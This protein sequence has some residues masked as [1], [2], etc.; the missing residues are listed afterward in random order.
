[1]KFLRNLIL[2][3]VVAMSGSLTTAFQT[4]VAQGQGVVQTQQPGPPGTF[5]VHVRLIPVD[6]I[7]TDP[8][9]H[10]ITDL[11]REDFQ[12]LENGRPQEIRHFSVQTFTADAP[13]PGQRPLLRNVPTLELAPQLART[14]L[15]LMGRGRHQTPLKAVDAL[16]QFVR[17]DLLPQDRVAV[18]AYNSATDF[19]TDH[20]R[21][22]QVL[23]RYKKANDKI[24]SWLELHLRG[25]ATVYGIKDVPKSVQPEIDRIFA[26]TQTL[27]SRQVPPGRITEKGTIIRDWD[28]AADVF[29]RDTDRASETDARRAV[30]DQIAE[31][32]GPG[33]QI[34]QNMIRFDTIDAAF[35]TF[36]L[37]F[38]EFAP[39]AGGSFQDLQN[40]FT[41]IEYLRYMEGEKHLIFFSGDGLLFPNGN[42]EYDKGL[43]AMSNDARVAI[44]SFQTSGTFA[45]P[46]IVPTKG[47]VL[48]TQPRGSTSPVSPPPPVLSQ[49]NWSRS[50][51][52]ST[53]GSFSALTGGRA[54]IG[55]DIGKAL[56]RLDETTRVEYLLGYYPKDERWDGQYRQIQVKLNRPGTKVSFRHGYYARDTLRP[57]DREEFLAFS[58]I[59][60]AGAY[61]SEVGDIPLKITAAREAGSQPQIKVDLQIDPEKVGFKMV[62]LRHVGRLRI[63]IFYADA[64]G[65]SLGDDWKTVDMELQE[66]SYQQIMQSG[67]KYSALIPLKAP[68]QILKVV[69]YDTVG[70]RVGSKLVKFK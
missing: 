29:L 38:D 25:L 35:V 56:D 46:E 10:P 30:A 51:M 57:Y 24:E 50:F 67:I 8:R 20:E 41:C 31:D 19:T 2:I 21:I 15:F 40:L 26:T 42:V 14:F 5:R 64:N 49:T 55:V 60:A 43:V 54:T 32:G 16:I 52:L 47:V 17:K 53:L 13:L 6:V 34:M 36:S 37:P 48:P 69:V 4:T 18:F 39:K 11:K 27:A 70:D 28:R 66:D 62:D 63:A 23:E 59:S 12:I 58:R 33:S 45:D 65:N 68:N 44:H 22:A 1:M 61:E 9:D 7:V 3:S